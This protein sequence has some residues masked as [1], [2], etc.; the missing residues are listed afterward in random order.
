MSIVRMDA[1]KSAAET[2]LEVECDVGTIDELL[3][4]LKGEVSTLSQ[5]TE[6][7]KVTIQQLEALSKEP[8]VQK[9]EIENT[10]KHVSQS[11]FVDY[12]GDENSYG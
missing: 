3:D 8:C 12:E 7:I 10:V 5:R 11:K 2:C 6:D 9:E 1:V 4:V